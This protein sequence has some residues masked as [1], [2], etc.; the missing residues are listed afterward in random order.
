MTSNKIERICGIETYST[1]GNRFCGI[2]KTL[3]ED[4]IVEEIDPNK[5]VCYVDHESNPR[6]DN[7]PTKYIEFKVRKKNIDTFEAVRRI[8]SKLNHVQDFIGFA[9]MKDKRA[10]TCQRMSYSVKFEKELKSMKFNNMKLFDF[11]YI[12]KRVKLGDLY[13]N[14]F[15]LVIRNISESIKEIKN[16]M[17]SKYNKIINGI[18]AFNFYGL[19][20]FGE[21][22]P[23]THTCGKFLLKKDIEGCVKTY[24]CQTFDGENTLHKEFRL[25]LLKN[26]DLKQ[27]RK[28][29][30]KNLYYEMRILDV[31][32]K[33]KDF[34]KAFGAF[35][36][37]LRRLF[38]HAYQS[39]LFNK[40]LSI[41]SKIFLEKEGFEFG[42]QVLILDENGLPTKIVQN[43]SSTNKNHLNNLR[44]NNRACLAA[45]IIGV[46]TKIHDNTLKELLEEE[47]IKIEDFKLSKLKTL[48]P[49][50]LFRPV[51]FKPEDF[52]LLKI[53]KDRLNETKNQLKIAFKLKKGTYAT[54]LLREFIKNNKK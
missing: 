44:L 19:Q 6:S 43:V 35:P 21:V 17:E 54:V 14:S 32:I 36:S 2:I 13:G 29:I 26:W 1:P 11:R 50:G 33:T 25:N 41:K 31:L 8:A 24:L 15:T 46:D 20:R 9:G 34:N 47:E 53:E 28:E 23:I 40:Y 37:D 4:F 10:I 27:A 3:P 18:G 51:F 39:Y 16:L 5:N 52:Q 45:P 42:D 30:P 22:R 12:K 7:A 49:K 48:N 38:I